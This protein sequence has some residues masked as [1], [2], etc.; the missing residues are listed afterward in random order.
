MHDSTSFCSFRS[1]LSCLN[2][3]YVCIMYGF[4]HSLIHMQSNLIYSTSFTVNLLCYIHL[5]S[6]CHNYCWESVLMDQD[7]TSR[8]IRIG[9]Y[10]FCPYNQGL[11][12]EP[13]T[14]P[15][16]KTTE[17]I[18]LYFT[19]RKEFEHHKIADLVTV[20]CRDVCKEGFGLSQVADA[21]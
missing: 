19:H 5:S 10:K 1:N 11:R 16:N 9:K 12:R 8:L 21:G 7:Q 4:F 2:K 15:F 13:F 3:D 14:I 18:L 6:L 20:T 17:T